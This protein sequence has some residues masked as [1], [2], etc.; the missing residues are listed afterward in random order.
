MSQGSGL[1]LD[2]GALIA[3]EKHTAAMRQAVKGAAARGIRVTVPAVVLVEWWRGA[4]EQR[5]ILRD[6]TVE[7]TTERVAKAAGEALDELNESVSVVDAV[8]MAFAAL[9]GD[10]V[11]TSDPEDLHNLQ[12]IFKGVTVLRAG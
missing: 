3:L 11:Y 9:R 6:L 2:T 5:K 4:H 1:T 12:T 7:S 10:I 8:V